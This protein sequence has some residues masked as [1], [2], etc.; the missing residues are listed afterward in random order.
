MTMISSTTGVWSYRSSA[1][2]VGSCKSSAT[3]VWSY[4]SSATGVGSCKS[5]ATGV[6]FWRSEQV[7]TTTIIMENQ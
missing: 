6:W 3:G 7:A 1:T 4:I 5:S 2:G